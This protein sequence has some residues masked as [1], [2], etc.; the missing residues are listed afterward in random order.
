MAKFNEILVGRYN[1]YLQ[2]LLAIKGGPPSSQLATEVGVQIQLFHGVETHYLE[3]WNI[4]ATAFTIPGVANI[5]GAFRFRNPGGS[6]IVAVFERISFF[7][8]GA[9]AD[10]PELQQQTTTADLPTAFAPPGGPLDK[11]SSA[12]GSPIVSNLVISSSGATG[13]ALQRMYKLAIPVNQTADFIITDIQEWPL[14]PGD[15]LQVQSGNAGVTQNV[16]I[17]ARWRERF[18]EDSERN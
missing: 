12:G 8:G 4:F 10:S 11:R 9:A 15:A 3:G 14:L 6:N 13:P 1:R 5:P 17:S 16:V 18:L 2:K 7:N